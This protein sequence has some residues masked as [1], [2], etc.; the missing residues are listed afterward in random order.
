MFGSV[1]VYL[2]LLDW[3]R[4]AAAAPAWVRGGA[5]SQET[6]ASAALADWA[7][8]LLGDLAS[9]L[10]ITISAPDRRSHSELVTATTELALGWWWSGQGRYTGGCRQVEVRSSDPDQRHRGRP[11][12]QRCRPSC[13]G[14]DTATTGAWP[15]SR[16][17]HTSRHTH[18]LA[19]SG[20]G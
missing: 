14:G 3:P 13:L 6:N 19:S 15:R 2:P 10:D 17:R 4:A 16:S 18:T 1:D 9:N 11:G 8:P 5:R 20:P 12:Q 7:R